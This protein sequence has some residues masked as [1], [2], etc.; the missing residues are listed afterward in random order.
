MV[1]G[2]NRPET[3]ALTGISSSRLSYLDRTELIVPR[4]FGNP[5]HPKVVYRWEQVLEI[6]TIER[7]REKLSLQEIRRVLEFLRVKNHKPSLFA[8]SLVFVN[9]QL[10][11]IEDVKDFGLT[12]LEAS[13]KNKGQVV[14]REVGP[15]GDV[16]TELC[17][18]AEKHQVLDFDK[19]I[20][21]GAINPVDKLVTN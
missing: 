11:L 21:L 14:I 7:L 6:K 17:R 12:V 19:R 9:S 13:G 2:F 20:C 3:I 10:Y 8:H 18:E 16:I 5:K 15:V 1:S 4:K